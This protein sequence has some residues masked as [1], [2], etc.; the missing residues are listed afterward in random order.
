MQKQNVIRVLRVDFEVKKLHFAAAGD[1]ESQTFTLFT[2][3]VGPND[4]IRIGKMH[5]VPDPKELRNQSSVSIEPTREF[6]ATI[7]GLAHQTRMDVCDEHTHQFTEIPRFSAIDDHHGKKNALYLSE[8]LPE[9]ATMLMTVFGRGLKHFQARVWNRKEGCF[10]PVERLEIIGSPLEILCQDNQPTQ[11]GE[12]PYAR[13]RI[14]PGWEQGRLERL[15]V[16][17]VGLGGNGAA[18]WQGLVGSGVGRSGGWLKGCDGDH[19]EASNLPRIPYALP[20]DIGKPK[21]VV[22]QRYARRKT[23]GLHVSCYQDSIASESMQQVAKEANV[24]VGA[25][26][27]DGGRKI[28]NGIAIRYLVVY[29]D[30]STEIIP[31]KDS[32]EAVGQVRVVIP[33]KTGCLICSGTIDPTE[34]ALDLLSQES[35]QERARV[36]YVR[37]SDE[38]PTP[39]VSHLNGVTAHLAMS[40]L[41][42]VVFGEAM[43]GKEFLHYDRQNCEMIIASCPPIPDCPV[44]GTKGYLG[45]GDEDSQ[46]MLANDDGRIRRVRFSDGKI[47]E[48]QTSKDSASEEN[49]PGEPGKRQGPIEC[50]G[51]TRNA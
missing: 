7:Y 31:E 22:A 44:C 51:M 9:P 3:A 40:Q 28:M 1:N 17:V 2:R 15:R 38:T 23:P 4:M 30:L 5:F 21:A 49:E 35:R 25:V 14:I 50:V 46:P 10:E 26:D 39:S 13:H 11:I 48:E 19:I 18:V 43:E 36:G 29:L 42:R 20:E 8:H 6:Q 32:F 16:F 34:A 45:A 47:I 24:I 37:G 12:D 41:L 27:N 33:G